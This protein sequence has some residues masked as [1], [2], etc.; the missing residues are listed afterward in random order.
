MTELHLSILIPAFLAGILVLST[1]VPLGQEVLKRGIIF[2][3]LAIAQ[4]AALG[5]IS[6]IV[7]GGELA[8]WQVQLFATLSAVLG[9]SFIYF[10]ES[11]FKQ[12]LEAI[13]GLI[14]V[15]AASGALMLV[16]IAPHSDELLHDLLVGQIIWVSQTQLLTTAI[17]YAILL[18]VWFRFASRSSLMFYLIFALTVTASVQLVGIY[19]VFASLILPALASRQA[20]THKVRLLIAYVIGFTGYALGILLSLL[21]DLPTGAVIVWCLC[22]SALL[23]KPILIKRQSLIK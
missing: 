11:H 15:L 4:I 21:L 19:L 20:K 12:N 1:H 5:V 7:F 14:F 17:L 22:L 23:L 9:A 18:V 13:I 2:I 6:A 10:L 8:Q 16:S 3:D